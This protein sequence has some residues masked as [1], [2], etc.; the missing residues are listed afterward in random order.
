M[1]LVSEQDSNIMSVLSADQWDWPHDVMTTELFMK[2]TIATILATGLF[3]GTSMAA[4]A[5]PSGKEA[6]SG[7]YWW[8]HPRRG[9]VKVDRATNAIVPS[10]RTADRSKQ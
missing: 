2:K 8:L 4:Y 6:A 1:L 10:K 5:A 9:M 7:T 3:V